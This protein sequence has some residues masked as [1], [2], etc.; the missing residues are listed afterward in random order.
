MMKYLILLACSFSFLYSFAQTQGISYSSVGRG[1]ATPFVTDYQALGI[2]VSALGYRNKYPNK[3]ITSGT[4]EFSF[5]LYSDS[6]SSQKLGN[7]TST[8]Y[9]AAIHKN[10]NE[11]DYKRQLDA[12]ANYAETGI[13]INVDYNWLGFS[14]QTPKFGGIAFNIRESYRWYSQLNKQTTDLIFR[15]KI[16]SLFDSLTVVFGTDTSRI[17]NHENISQDTLS[18][19]ILGTINV[20]I[21]LSQMTRGSSIQMLWTRSYNLGYGRRL[22]GVD[23]IFE[24]Y[25]GVGGRYITSMAM[26]DMRSDE[27]GLYM[28][29]SITSKFDINYGN[30]N[31]ANITTRKSGIAPVVGS[32]YGI[33][34]AASIVLF[35]RLKV[36]LAVNNIGSVTYKRNVY[37]AKDTLI[38]DLSLNGLSTQDFT[39]SIN[40]L[41]RENGIFTLQGQEKYTV[42]NASDIRFGIA[43]EAKKFIRFG[44]DF[45][46]P[47]NKENPGSIQNPVYSFGGDIIPVKW[48]QLSVGYFGGGVYKN[49]I[50]IGITFILRDGAY[51]CGIA[52]R[53]AISF[54][55][56]NGNSVSTAFGFARFRF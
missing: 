40:Q 22:F 10:P 11:I 39:K 9:N 31:G 20:P 44:F 23:S 28:Y 54:F 30:V 41:I 45:V 16:S 49:N 17:A 53:D 46:A 13:G 55:T 56:K 5:G 48:L 43:Y 51:E 37:K 1:V 50:P 27:S 3:K 26:F 24:V 25:A 7:L 2:N 52:S 47:F 6:L 15:G 32:G 8:L 29:S 12:V 34:L 36:A 38:G 35:N 4:S 19:V 14:F 21:Q 42:I 18:N 33:D